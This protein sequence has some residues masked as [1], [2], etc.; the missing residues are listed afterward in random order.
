MLSPKQNVAIMAQSNM[1]DQEIYL[2]YKIE[3]DTLF[4]API[5]LLAPFIPTATEE[6][7]CIACMK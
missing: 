3:S 6:W 4:I 2:K 5:A 7:A 1:R